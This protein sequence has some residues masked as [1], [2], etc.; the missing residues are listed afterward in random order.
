M[1][2]I[3]KILNY[4]KHNNTHVPKLLQVPDAT[5]TGELLISKYKQGDKKPVNALIPIDKHC[6][7]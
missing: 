2:F 3:L 4:Y 6:I 5:S 1:I 7:V